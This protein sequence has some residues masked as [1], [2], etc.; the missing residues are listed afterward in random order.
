[1]VAQNSELPN[2]NLYVDHDSQVEEEYVD[3]PEYSPSLKNFVED[4]YN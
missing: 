4:P 1:M 2:L 3:Q